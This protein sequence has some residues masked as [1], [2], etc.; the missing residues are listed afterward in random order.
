[1]ETAQIYMALPDEV[2][3]VWRPIRPVRLHDDVYR[4]VDQAYDRELERW[5][6][7]P[8]E[9]VLC[10]HIETEDGTILAATTRVDG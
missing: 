9:Q 5:Q 7:E 2:V 1:L 6:F 4:I 8:G 3:P 10:E